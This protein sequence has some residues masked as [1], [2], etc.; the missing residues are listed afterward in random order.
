MLETKG[1]NTVS[2]K[3]MIDEI[4]KNKMEILELKIQKPK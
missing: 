2:K 3:K 4:K 1:K